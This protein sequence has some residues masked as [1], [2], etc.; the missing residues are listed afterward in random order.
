MACDPKIVYKGKEYTFSEFMSM[1]QDG[2]VDIN[3]I[4]KGLKGEDVDISINEEK[5]NT[6]FGKDVSLIEVE[7]TGREVEKTILGRAKR[8]EGNTKEFEDFLE[9]EGLTRAMQ[10]QKEVQ[11][12]VEDYV[13]K[14]GIEKTLDQVRRGNISGAPR[15]WVESLAIQHFNIKKNNP[16]LT[17]AERAEAEKQHQR[18]LKETSERKT[19]TGQELAMLAY[20]YQNIEGLGLDANTQIER[21]KEVNGGYISPELEA[22]IIKQA[23]ELDKLHAEID[24]MKK[25]MEAQ[26]EKKVIEEVIKNKTKPKKEG[27]NKEKA[28]KAADA[29]R[30]KFKLKEVTFKD[31]KGNDIKVY[32]NA[33]LD[34]NEFV[35]IVAKTVEKTGEIS[36][37]IREAKKK[38][39]EQEWYK[40]LTKEDKKAIER[41]IEGIATVP[42]PKDGL[43][44]QYL[45]EVIESGVGNY[46]EFIERI[47]EDFPEK[48]ETEIAKEISN[49]AKEVSKSKSQIEKDLSKYKRMALITSQIEDILN[50]N[51][52]KKSIFRT[53]SP[54]AELRAL[55][56]E[57][58][59][60]MRETD[61]Q[62]EPME[63]ELRSPLD[64][65]KATAKNRIEQLNLAIERNQKIEKSKRT[66]VKDQELKDLQ[67]ERDATQELYDAKFDTLEERAIDNIEKQIEEVNRRIRENELESEKKDPAYKYS[68]KYKS[69]QERLK[70]RKKVLEEM[71]KE[72]GIIEK[73]RLENAKTR[74][75]KRID[76]MNRQIQEK[77]FAKKEIKPILE[78]NE[79]VK[80][81]MKADEI[82]YE[83]DKEVEKY[84]IANRTENEKMA[85]M[86]AS[87]W[88]IPR[89]ARATGELSFVGVQGLI[90]TVKYATKNPKVLADAFKYTF[91]NMFNQ[92][93]SEEW[94][95]KIRSQDNYDLITKVMKVA[96]TEPNAKIDAAE[97][98]AYSNWTNYVWDKLIAGGVEKVLGKKAAE[99]T[100]DLNPFKS[101]ERGAVTYLDYMR[102]AMA[103]DALETFGKEGLNPKTN[104]KEFQDLGKYI[105]TMTGR[106]QLLSVIEKSPEVI[107]ALS[108]V[109]FSPR[110]WS[111][112]IQRINP[113]WYAKLSPEVA[114]M[115]FKDMG[116]MISLAT[117]FTIA[118]AIKLNNDDDPETGVETDANSSDF[119]QIKLGNKR[120]DLFA[121]NAKSLILWHRAFSKISKSSGGKERKL[122]TYGNKKTSDLFIDAAFNKVNPAFGIALEIANSNKID[123]DGS[124]FER[125]NA[126]G[127]E[128]NVFSKV[129]KGT[130]TPIYWTETLPEIVKDNPTPMDIFL[131]MG[132]F[133]GAPVNVYNPP[134]K[135]K[136]TFTP[137][138]LSSKLQ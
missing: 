11:A 99:K 105:N 32:K 82:K 12:K 53:E 75:Q 14:N 57:L 17:E 31:A 69:A 116:R 66:T 29:I 94:F 102:L 40:S 83:W 50:G 71:R 45:K 130:L 137:T 107:K 89:T 79:L 134:K 27:W 90:P 120:I 117:A 91:R 115:A 96:I 1:M 9:K 104:E 80:L 64:K 122:N 63:D 62:G 41:Q 39:K 121:G 48:P 132:A 127:E 59:T 133:F 131:A 124:I 56:Q 3:A 106:G 46:E 103:N 113:F 136:K 68:D 85:D 7:G 60:L 55:R 28:K 51:R 67:E 54:D 92:A 129:A 30:E 44:T 95:K 114:E 5:I 110:L 10:S 38:L 138:P 86:L 119:M 112:K 33:I 126:Y 35:E 18:L 128:F 22:K 8:A 109:F 49:Y 16:N 23:E 77:D 19:L 15:T 47:R 125:K 43:T 87:F 84:R 37:G 36:E 26:E 111:A 101:F 123:E 97:E 52:P 70:E 72:A 135:G 13:A 118:A 76:E 74:L 25:S 61:F 78:D 93:K 20:A 108:H 98:S 65:L 2:L 34:F 88:N 6:S 58:D 24:A 81:R 100:V 4:K 73:K 21:I 42:D